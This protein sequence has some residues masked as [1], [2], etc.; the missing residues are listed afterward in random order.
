VFS[1][2]LKWDLHPNPLSVLLAEKRRSTE[3]ILDLTESNPTRAGIKYPD[4]A[5][6]ESL[7]DAVSLQYEPS[8]EGLLSARQAIAT[9]YAERCVSV[10][11]SQ[12]LLTASTS[13]AYS[14][15]FKLLTD[16]GDEVLVPRPSYPLY[17]FLAGLEF[18]NLRQYPLRYDGVWHIDFDALKNAITPRAK[19]IVVV[20][21]NNPTGSF[22]KRGEAE[23]LQEIAARRGLAI[24]SDEVF[25]DYAFGGDPS[26]MGTLSEANLALTFCMSG[27]SKIA[28]LPQMKLG[29]IAASGPE[30]EA[31]LERLHWI[32]D[33]Y[34]SVATPVQVALPRLLGLS[35]GI[36]SQ[37]Q[38]RTAA[39]LAL[40]Q[41]LTA[42]SLASVLNVEGGWYA[43]LQVPSTRSDE[44]WSHT[45][46]RDCD[47]LVQPGFFYD[48]ESD[49][50]LVLSLLT[51]PA[52]F[53]EGV[54]RISQ[55][56]LS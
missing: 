7:T 48:A 8:P 13:E 36:R 37:I 40:L 26:R 41:E 6:L 25:S 18:V 51:E 23:Q 42:G 31:A 12:I 4:R 21:P 29:W 2:R 38:T 17:E 9:Y 47:V 54:C 56:L 44:E 28:G 11:P 16:P 15:L 39:N 3:D 49:A 55:A 22:V 45:L 35:S 32:G 24:L 53:G 10:D 14:Y 30:S 5:I 27:L 43:I 52:T 19:A 33:T 20:N 46:L 34:L 1:S 50:Y